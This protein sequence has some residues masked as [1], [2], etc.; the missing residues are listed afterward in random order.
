MLNQVTSIKI[1]F[2]KKS[3]G[4][5]QLQSIQSVVEVWVKLVPVRNYLV[6]MTTL[7]KTLGSQTMLFN[8]MEVGKQPITSGSTIT[9]GK[10][11]HAESKTTRLV[12]AKTF[13]ARTSKET[14]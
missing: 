8:D 7:V 3:Q 4:T 14:N 10:E 6:V 2:T 12:E 1:I 5:V 9:G 13:N 11:Y